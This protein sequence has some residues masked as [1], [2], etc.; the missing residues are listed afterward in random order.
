MLN[1]RMEYAMKFSSA[2]IHPG[3]LPS[4]Y[5]VNEIVAILQADPQI[6]ARYGSVQGM[7]MHER[8]SETMS[9]HIVIL[10]QHHRKLL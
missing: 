8:Q 4:V 10:P 7:K 3:L 5:L 6:V 2:T 9:K 1:K